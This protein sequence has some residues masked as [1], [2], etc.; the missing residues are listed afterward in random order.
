MG[1]IGSVYLFEG[2][3]KK[4]ILWNE[5]G[6][7]IAKE[8][9]DIKDRIGRNTTL[10][11]AYKKLGKGDIALSYLEKN[12]ALKDTLKKEANLNQ[13]QKMEF[14]K[15]WKADSLKQVKRDLE[16][17]Q[18][19]QDEVNKK[20]NSRV[21][22]V[23]S[24]ILLLLLS[25]V[26]YKRLKNTRKSKAELLE[27]KEL[28]ENLLLNIL[29]VEIAD[30]LKRTGKTEARNFDLVSIL[31]TDF[32]GFTELSSRLSPE[33]LVEEINVC[34]EE[35]DRIISKHGVEKIKTIGDAYMAAG[36]LPVSSTDSVKNTVIAAIE[37]QKF[38][39]KRKA[40]ND[41][42]GIPAFEMRLGIHTGPIVA[43]IVGIK[44][45]QYDVWGDTVNTASRIESNGMS[46]K[47]NISQATFEIIK[48]NPEFIFE[49]RG[50][51]LAKGKGE[52]EMYFV[53]GKK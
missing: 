29:P 32:V 33:K 31:F 41:E 16:A 24:A 12:A 44:K 6:N 34:F 3:L 26:L 38:I 52:I 53:E 45:F 49:N 50:M 25:F 9:G 13:L 7:E 39:S 42:L 35:F 14:D 17:E 21:L 46:G 40:Q 4:A 8:T 5:K 19:L 36:G 51:I 30:E 11:E 27:E 20:N 18:M 37:M 23:V 15:E 47:V 28:S 22:M 2:D 43:G 10:Y 1:S 48:E